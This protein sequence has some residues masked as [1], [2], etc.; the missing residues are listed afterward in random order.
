MPDG[1][2]SFGAATDIGRMRERN[3]D[4]YWID[5]ERGIFLVVDGVGGQ[6]GGEL[7]A[8]TAVE[9]I[10]EALSESLLEPAETIRNAIAYAN[11]CIFAL[12]QEHPEFHS[13]ACVLTLALVQDGRITIGHVGDSRLYLICKG[14]IRKLTSD[15]SP[16]GED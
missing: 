2:H 8:E 11:N 15:H 14:A 10:R 3:E 6:A 7:A 16:A 1:I 12:A 13:M 4:R 5:S 9:A